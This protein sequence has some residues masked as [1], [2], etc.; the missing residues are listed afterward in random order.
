MFK[1]HTI[2]QVPSPN[3][4]Q[5]TCKKSY[6]TQRCGK[7]LPI[8]FKFSYISI[9]ISKS[10]AFKPHVHTWVFI[11]LPQWLRQ[12]AVKSHCNWFFS[13]QPC[14][15]ISHFPVGKSILGIYILLP[16]VT[17]SGCF[18]Y[19]YLGDTICSFFMAEALLV[20]AEDDLSPLPGLGLFLVPGKRPSGSS[21]FL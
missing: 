11:P 6:L 2:S 1:V 3:C 15:S 14:Q 9:P 4:L 17:Y 10:K 21:G 7:Y 16:Q 12:D 13:I 8:F 19:S 5:L 18:L 20:W